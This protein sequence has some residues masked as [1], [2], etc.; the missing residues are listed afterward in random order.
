MAKKVTKPPTM[1]LKSDAL[2]I[3]KEAYEYVT[4][5]RRERGRT[6]YTVR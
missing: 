1:A 3:F 6:A 5:K 2:D 4:R